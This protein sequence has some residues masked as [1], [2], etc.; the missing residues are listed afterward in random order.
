M[1]FHSIL[2]KIGGA[3]CI[4][5]D[6]T[7][8]RLMRRRLQILDALIEIVETLVQYA[9]PLG[10]VDIP[11]ENMVTSMQRLG[12]TILALAQPLLGYSHALIFEIQVDSHLL[13]LLGIIGFSTQGEDLLRAHPHLHALIPDPATIALLQRQELIPFD[14]AQS[15]LF[16]ELFPDGSVPNCLFVPIYVASCLAGLFCVAFADHTSIVSTEDKA[17]LIAISKL[18][19]LALQYEQQTNERNRLGEARDLLNEQLEH[20]NELQST[21]ISVVGHE[22]RTALTGI[23]GFSSLLIEEDFTSEETREFAC[24]IN[25]DAIR[26]HHMITDLLDLE[27]MKKGKMQLHVER[28][29]INAIMLESVKR[30]RLTKP[31]YPLHMYLDPQ[32]PCLQGDPDKLNQVISNLLS[33]A[34]KYSPDRGEIVVRSVI[35]GNYLH[36][37][38]QDHGIGIPPERLKDI[39]TPYQR[40]ASQSTCYIQG[41]GLGLGIVKQIVELHQGEIWVES[42]LGQGSLFHVTL[43]LEV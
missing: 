9:G 3:I 14:I 24:D 21:F 23:E 12:Q 20:V 30:I 10:I 22:F 39:F 32:H 4:L 1:P 38:V 40:I 6:V 19:A 31:D 42:V 17:L 25:K 13:S 41:T 7:E 37:S 18:C 8:Q 34:V 15:S 43:P 26:L 5:R 33:N 35:E 2:K 11:G 36:V 27:Q 29:D 16:R 28:V